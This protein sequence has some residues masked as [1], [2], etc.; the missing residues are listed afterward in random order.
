[1]VRA[2][3]V[4]QSFD[5]D[6][7][8]CTR[9]SRSTRIDP[10]RRRRDHDAPDRRPRSAAARR[11][12]GPGRVGAAVV[13]RRGRGDEPA[14]PGDASP[15]AGPT[16]PAVSARRWRSSSWRASCSALVLASRGRRVLAVLLALAGLGVAAVGALRQHTERRQRSVRGSGSSASSSSSPSRAP[17]GPGSTPS[18]G[19]RVVGGARPAVRRCPRLAA[20][21]RSASSVVPARRR[22]LRMRA[23]IRRGPGAPSTPGVDPTSAGDER[24]DDSDDADDT[25]TR[26]N[27]DPD[28]RTGTTTDTMVDRARTPERAGIPIPDRLRRGKRTSIAA[29][30][31]GAMTETSQ[32]SSQTGKPEKHIHHGR[33]GA[34]WAGTTHRPRGVPLGSRRL[35]LGP[36]W[37]MFW[38]GI[39]LLVVALIVT[40]V[41]QRMGYGAN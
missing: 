16:R 28:V 14:G 1:M 8:V 22:R 27:D 17:P 35:G 3:A 6:R 39:A 21:T 26:G 2:I 33:T 32:S 15:S 4:A 24:A 30:E 25:P 11:A 34:A 36:N 37:V 40:V 31:R 29:A 18:P 7:S 19:S 13:A 38:V 5:G 9:S 20:A 41:M 10:R 23:T 12:A